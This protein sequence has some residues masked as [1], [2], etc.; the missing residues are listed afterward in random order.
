MRN[1]D[2]AA[3]YVPKGGVA[4][5]TSTAH[6]GVAAATEHDRDVVLIDLAGTQND[7]ATH[8][9]LADEVTDPDAPISAVFGDEW[10]FIVNNIDD[11]LDRMVYS[12]GEGPD[13]IP[14]D[15]GLTGADNNLASVPVES[16]YLKLQQFVQDLLAEEYDLVLFDLPGKEDNIALNGIIAA[17]H[18]VAPLCPGTFE[19]RQ[20][21]SLS[22]DLKQI[23]I[24]LESVLTDLGTS[25]HLSMVVPTMISGRTIQSAEFV[26]DIEEAYPEIASVAVAE[27]Q[28]I[29]SL[30]NEGRTLFDAEDDEL[31][32]TGNRAREAY[33]EITTTLLTTINHE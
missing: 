16:R 6:I 26:E 10:N 22:E 31:Y 15:D 4:K 11:I 27:S 9:G 18:I 25:P 32:E 21:N 19:R 29:A 23:R 13:L 17:E 5:T 1:P 8:F 12:T 3:M 2:T 7:L 24:D 14:A 28:N 30:Q 20:L 33:Q